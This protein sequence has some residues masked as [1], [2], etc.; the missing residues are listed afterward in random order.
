MPTGDWA[1]EMAAGPG[2][3]DV[4]IGGYFAY[5]WYQESHHFATVVTNGKELS[6]QMADTSRYGFLESLANKNTAPGRFTVSGFLC[7]VDSPGETWYDSVAKILYVYPP[8]LSATTAE[9]W[10]DSESL[11][12]VRFGQ[13]GGPGLISLDGTSHVTVRDMV[14]SGAGKGIIVGIT[15]GDHNVVGGCTLKNSNAVAV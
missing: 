1:A 2:F 15:G 3:G 12:A 6:V 11:A 9:T 5:D 7:E 4:T 8:P 14:V 13:W 10:W